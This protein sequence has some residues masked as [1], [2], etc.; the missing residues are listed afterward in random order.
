[1]EKSEM[2]N[3]LARTGADRNAVPFTLDHLAPPRVV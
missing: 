1:M 2:A 3:K